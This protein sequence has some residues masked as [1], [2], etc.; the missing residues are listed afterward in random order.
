MDFSFFT[1]NFSLPS[2]VV[3]FLLFNFSFSCETIRT[4]CGSEKPK[5]KTAFF[6]CL[7]THLSLSLQKNTVMQNTEIL[8]IKNFG[9]INNATVKISKIIVMIGEQGA[10]KSCVAKLYSLF[11]W[12]EKALMRHVLT[13]R[14]V[15][16]Y[17]RFRKTYAAYNGIDGYFKPDTVLK[18]NGFHYS[19]VYENEKLAI[20]ENNQDGDLF[21]I[22]KVMYVPAERNVLGSVEHPT[23]L[24]GLSEPM[25]T[26]L[27]EYDK[28]KN[29]IK[30]GYKMPFGEVDFEYDKL[31]DIS[32][33]KHKDYEIKLSE[34]SSGFQSALPLLLVS[35][36][37]SNIVRD[38]SVKADLSD[39]ER[40]ALQKEVDLILS[41][42]TLS[43]D[44]KMASLR[45][46]SSKYRYSRFVNVVEEMELNLFP[47][48][49]K[50]VL[51]ELVADAYKLSGNRL[52]MTTHSPYVINY[53][54]LSVKAMQLAKRAEGLEDLLKRIY[55]VVPMSG[56]IN[57]DDL[58]I[59][60]L[61]DGTVEQLKDYEGLPSDDNY[62]NVRLKDTNN[63][64]DDLLEIE[65]DLDR[66]YERKSD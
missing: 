42:N 14:Y 20:I 9:P 60:E 31:N 39:K 57:T 6:I 66:Y 1:F 62:L 19:F 26:F 35:E 21:N 59:Y 27:D 4:N 22:A 55:D 5:L 17:S 32:K 51:Y 15:M 50:N 10:G 37:L 52:V 12:L 24:R 2:G 45:M 13:E 29:D 54:T 61:H 46:V 33:L 7:F 53:L 40:K 44:V 65:E 30:K 3:Y 47:D 23:R 25:M 36:N 18:F 63:A 56:M 11:S 58:I 48:S 8:S 28:A 34:A 16:Q 43:D 49:Q 38:N 64:F 41:D